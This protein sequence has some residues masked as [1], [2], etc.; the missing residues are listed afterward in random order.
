[1]TLD[2]LTLN[3]V[4]RELQKI[5]V[6]SKIQKVS[7]PTKEEIVLQLY[8]QENG[9]FK[10]TLS[11]NAGECSVRITEVTKPNPKTAPPFCMLLRKYLNGARI[12]N[13][14]QQGLNRVIDME[15][16]SK[17]ELMRDITLHLIT[18]IMGKYSNIILT[19][20]AY[21]ILDS[22]KR[23]GA[24]TSSLRTILPGFKYTDPP[25]EKLNPDSLSL[26]TIKEA[27]ITRKDTKLAAHM[28]SVFNGIST[29]TADEVLTRADCPNIYT[30][31]ITEKIA[32]RI[33]ETLKL[34]L[35]DAIIN[36]KPAVQLNGDGLPVF[37]SIVPYGAF[38]EETRVSFDSANKMLDYYYAV[39]DEKFRLTQ[40]KDALGRQL[41][42]MLS[43][44][45]KLINIYESSI[46]DAGRIN[47]L[48]HRADAIT[49]NMYR[50][51]KGMAEFK[52]VNYETGQPEIIALELSMT[53]QELAQK[54]YKKIA[55]IKKAASINAEKL[56]DA[57]EERDFLLGCMHYAEAAQ[58]AR[59]IDE[60][61]ESMSAAG[62]L[63]RTPAAKGKKV[64]ESEPLK[65]QAPG[66]YTVFVGK[67]D[68]QNDIL[69]MKTAS[70]DDIWFH[71]QKTPGSHVL[72]VTNGK[73]LDDI[74]DETV[75]FCASLAAAHSRAKQSGKTAV[76]YTHRKNIKKPPASHPGK[77][78]YDDYFTV[79]VEPN[80]HTESLK[81]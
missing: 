47:K 48:K 6:P 46:S 62:L 13:I 25:Q 71:A 2:G 4:T 26:T 51:K 39:R 55:K 81:S 80:T 8:S 30:G 68:R 72:L 42:K 32:Q 53:P 64:A 1:M 12:A 76:D 21:T 15:L 44:T 40:Q 5:A 3:A 23:V 14:S 41:G 58:T 74:E 7:M 77:V 35:N 16:A 60:I 29:Q 36:I 18:E 65:Y 69:T 78:I 50:L 10:L 79:Y 43:K 9:N 20:G 17:D 52:T 38:P 49:A 33:A 67:N 37:F 61:K 73:Q 19:D 63:P 66:G 59:D 28:T 34:F 54:I 31:D 45:Q 27:L 11:A 22:I 57:T 70:R 24:D 56:V 75:V